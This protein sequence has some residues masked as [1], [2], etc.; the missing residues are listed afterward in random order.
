MQKIIVDDRLK[1]VLKISLS[2]KSRKIF[3]SSLFFLFSVVIE[4]QADVRKKMKQ[5]FYAIVKFVFKKSE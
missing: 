2:K 3:S 4:L 1:A 5:I